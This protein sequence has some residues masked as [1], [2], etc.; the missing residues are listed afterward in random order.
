MLTSIIGA[1][2]AILVVIII[3]EFGHFIVA[4]MCGIHVEKFSIGFGRAL[5]T[6]TGRSGTKYILAVLPLGGYVKMLGDGLQD[7][8]DDPRAYVNKSVFKRMAVVL[9]G[10]VANFLLA[11]V[12]YMGIYTHGVRHI[13]P[14]IGPV[15]QGSIAAQAGLRTGEQILRVDSYPAVSWQHVLMAMLMRYGDKDKMQITVSSQGQVVTK[16]LNLHSWQF[17]MLK[18]KPFQSLGF[19]PYSPKI[20]AVLA[21]VVSGSAAAASGLQPGDKIISLDGNKVS[22]WQQMTKL[23]RA[24]PNQAIRL[25]YMRNNKQFSTRV[26]IGEELSEGAK[27]GVLG[28][29]AKIPPLAPNMILTTKSPWWLSWRPATRQCVLLL[30]YNVISLWKM[31]VGQ[32]STKA[33]G[34][35]ITIFRT[36]GTAAS[37]GI[38]EYTTFIAFISLMIGFVNLLPIPVLDGGHFMFQ[39]V[40]VV[41]G[42]PVSFAVQKWAM[43]GGLSVLLVLMLHA[44]V[45]DVL[46]FF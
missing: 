12:I 13:K 34:G 16:N 22:D 33:L 37:F 17:D 9:A 40:E 36:A 4:R 32:I 46:R 44:T 42:R 19:S 20:P 18:P 1:I 41:I 21:E 23:V 26:M 27:I 11:I 35:P 28:A 45:N 3:H 7:T 6:K 15:R 29:M 39:L 8:S 24:R 5:F 10:P 43:F 2:L 30:K 31:L 38:V 25:A 14:V